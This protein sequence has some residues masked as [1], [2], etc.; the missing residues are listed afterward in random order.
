MNLQPERIETLAFRVPVE[1]PVV[2][3]FGTMTY[4]PAL[5]VRITDSDGAEG[6]GEVFCNWPPRGFAHRAM[7]VHDAAAPLLLGRRFETPAAA[8]RHLTT[9]LHVL[10]IQTGEPGPMAQIAAGLDIA[11]W[12]IWARKRGE[13]LCR[14]LGGEA[15]RPLPVYA[16]GINPEDAL[17]TIDRCRE[18]GHRAFKIKV[19]IDTARDRA[20]ADAIAG[21][22]RDGEAWMVDANQ[23]WDV[24]AALAEAPFYG[25]RGAAWIEEPIA[26]DRPQEEWCA[27]AASTA[28]PLAAGENL[29]GEE[30]FEAAIAAGWLGVVQPDICKWGGLTGCLAVARGALAGGKRYCPHYLGGGIG[31]LASAHLLM[32]VGGDGLLEVDINPNPLRE[33]LAQPFPTF[34]DGRMTLA[35]VPGLGVAPDLAATADWRVETLALP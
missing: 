7:L 27:V 34:R 18:I 14:A 32:A 26:A 20:N 21:D 24:D 8:W 29:A 2:T 28:A 13:P 9:A 10:A 31:L 15:L 35:E 16:S 1:E 30:A 5:L 12:D 3:S 23:G 33:A 11:L 22:L 25:E 4:R 17:E 6:W 19:G